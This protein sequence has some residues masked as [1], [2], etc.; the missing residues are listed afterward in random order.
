MAKKTNSS[1]VTQPIAAGEL[2]RYFGDIDASTTN[3]VQIDLRARLAVD[4]IKAGFLARP[5]ELLKVCL[6]VGGTNAELARNVVAFA[7][8]LGE[9]YVE[10]AKQR[11]LLKDLPDF[12]ELTVRDRLNIERQVRKQIEGQKIGQRVMSEEGNRVMQ[13]APGGMRLP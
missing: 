6:P 8:D 4:F 1:D 10:Q 9:E 2:N 11:G 5:T 12:G 3:G 13:G 7:L